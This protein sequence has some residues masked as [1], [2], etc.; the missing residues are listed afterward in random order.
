MIGNITR[1]CIIPLLLIIMSGCTQQ[2]VEVTEVKHYSIDSIEGIISRSDLQIDKSISAD[3][4]GSL[5]ATVEKPTVL[6]LFETG[7]IDAEN[8]RLIYRAKLKT[9]NIEGTVYLEM[10]CS[11]PGKGEFF[12]RSLDAPLS[13]ST[14]WTIRETLFFLRK[15]EN[16][17]NVRLNVVINGTGR[18]WVDDV[19][20][21]KGPLK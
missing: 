11:F 4:N 20:L 21:I 10:W 9:E 19:S 1:Y 12:S 5:R 8:A 16:P 7:D 3:G 6:Q 17:D 18:I 15:G 14:D 2:P 13:K